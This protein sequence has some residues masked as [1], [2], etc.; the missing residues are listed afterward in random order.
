MT[1]LRKPMAMRQAGI[2]LWIFICF[3][4]YS[5]ESETT[6]YK[7]RS[8]SAIMYTRGTCI[9]GITFLIYLIGSIDKIDVVDLIA[10]GDSS[11]ASD[12]VEDLVPLFSLEM[13]YVN[14][15]HHTREAVGVT[16]NPVF[17]FGRVPMKNAERRT[18]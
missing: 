14:S 11:F 5:D 7:S 17:W 12:D 10:V 2:R 6:I 3:V 13:Y 18:Q 4:L 9:Y 1:R 8:R 15:Y 16:V